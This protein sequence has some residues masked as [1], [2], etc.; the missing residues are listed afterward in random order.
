MTT[1]TT[2]TH[3]IPELNARI[4]DAGITVPLELVNRF[5]TLHG[6][7]RRTLE[8]V[9]RMAGELKDVRAEQR[10][11]IDARFGPHAV[12]VEALDVSLAVHWK[13]GDFALSD[14]LYALVE[15]VQGLV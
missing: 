14:T 3:T 5:A 10:G 2:T 6:E 7:V 11:L 4:A 1:S 15:L 13:T 9:R 12:S 8:S